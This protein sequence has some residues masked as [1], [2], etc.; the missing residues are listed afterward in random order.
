[1]R[2][3]KPWHSHLDARTLGALAVMLTGWWDARHHP[4]ARM[5]AIAAL[6]QSGAEMEQSQAEQLKILAHRMGALE[7][8]LKRVDR[9]GSGET[10]PDTTRTAPKKDGL[11]HALRWLT[12]W[13]NREGE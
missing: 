4:E 1:M 11:L 9:R 3:R 2:R 12:P 13:R 5:N 8:R 7:A 10:R 6:S